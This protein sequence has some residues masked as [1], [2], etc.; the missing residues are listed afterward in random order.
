MSRSVGRRGAVVAPSDL[1]PAGQRPRI[2][3]G[4]N[5]V[6][7]DLRFYLGDGFVD[8]G[9]TVLVLFETPS[10][11]A[12]FGFIGIYL[13]ESDAIESMWAHFVHYERAKEVVWLNDFRTFD[14]KSSAISVGTGINKQLSEMIMKWLGPGQTLVVGKREYKSIIESSLGIHCLHDEIVMELMWGM[15][16]LMH[17]LVG[18]EKLE[19]PK[20]DRAPMSQGLQ[21]VLSRHGFHVKPE[22]VTEEIVVAAL[23]LFNYDA[24]CKEE[25]P[26]LRTIGRYLTDVS[27]IDCKTWRAVKLATAFKI[28][29][30]REIEDS[31]EMLPKDV[32]LKLLEDADGYNDLINRAACMNTYRRLVSTHR[33]NTRNKVILASLIKKAKAHEADLRTRGA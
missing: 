26:A 3:D 32:Q 9:G 12:I 31:D 10:G 14:D 15:Q 29:C 16:R 11:F 20:E 21:I 17:R 19:L 24:A 30:T 2:P 25:Y 18:R 28:I 27:G 7:G 6:M 1:S 4:F 8:N 13:Y 33:A 22:M 5:G 23:P